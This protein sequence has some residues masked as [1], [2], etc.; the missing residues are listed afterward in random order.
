[1]MPS[2]NWALRWYD[3]GFSYRVKK[4]DHF[5]D[6]ECNTAKHL[7]S[8]INKLY[9]GDEIQGYKV[10]ANLF[11]AFMSC[12]TFSMGMPMLYCFGCLIFFSQFLINKFLL[13]KYHSK[14]TMFG[15]DLALSS[16]D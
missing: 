8:E 14:T 12:M 10:Y 7:Q 6:V 4:D 1:M 2:V 15:Q 9:T 13:L 5:D 16:V 11:L 3:R